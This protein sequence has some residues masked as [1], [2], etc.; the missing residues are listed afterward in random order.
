MAKL[1]PHLCSELRSPQ[2]TQKLLPLQL[3]STGIME[4]LLLKL[5]PQRLFPAE[6]LV[7]LNIYSTIK[8]CLLF[9][10]STVHPGSL[11]PREGAGVGAAHMEDTDTSHCETSELPKPQPKCLGWFPTL[12]LMS[13]VKIIHPLLRIRT[14][15]ICPFFFFPKLPL[16]FLC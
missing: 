5:L 4:N 12:V 16:P 11:C 9:Q 13:S 14:T 15:C 10:F 8:L 6:V 1:L 7:P 2:T 3:L